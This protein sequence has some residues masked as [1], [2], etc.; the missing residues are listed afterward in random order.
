M[1]RDENTPDP[2]FTDTLELD[3]SSVLPSISGPKRPQDRIDLKSAPQGFAAALDKEY[4]KADEAD[5]RFPVA[6]EDYTLGHG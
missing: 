5:K 1:W 4:S 3:L 2:I 6:G